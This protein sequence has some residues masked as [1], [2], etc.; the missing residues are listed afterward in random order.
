MDS[1]D[2]RGTYAAVFGIEFRQ[3]LDPEPVQGTAFGETIRITLAIPSK[4]IVV[5][6]K[7][8]FNPQFVDEVL[9]DK[10][11][12][13]QRGHLFIKGDNRSGDQSRFDSIP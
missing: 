1:P 13:F 10:I 11:T 9:L 2:V 7:Q 5:A 3:L 6:H 8:S 12:C 4:T